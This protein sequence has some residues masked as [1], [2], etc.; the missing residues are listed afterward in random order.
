MKLSALLLALLLTGCAHMAILP[1]PRGCPDSHPIKGNGSS[2][3]YHV[4]GST[5][6]DRVAPEKCF[7]TERDAK[8]AGFR[9]PE[10][11]RLRM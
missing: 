6:Y 8:R 10:P 2:R 7:R 4:P 1:G 3:I 11:R 9:A 5:W